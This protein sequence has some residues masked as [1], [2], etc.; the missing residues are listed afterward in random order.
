MWYVSGAPFKPL[1]DLVPFLVVAAALSGCLSADLTKISSSSS[2]KNGSSTSLSISAITPTIGASSSSTPVTITGTGFSGTVIVTIGGLACTGV[3]IV[4]STQLTCVASSGGGSGTYDLIVTVGST[5]ATLGN[6]FTW[7]S[8]P[9]VTSVSPAGGPLAGGTSITVTGGN[10]STSGGSPIV[11]IG[12]LTCGSLLYIDSTQLTCSTPGNSAGAYSATVTNADTQSGSLASA[13]SYNNAPTVSGF[14][15]S[16]GS[17][18][19]GTTITVDGTG[20][21]SSP[22]PTVTVAGSSCGSVNVLSATQLQCVTSAHGTTFGSVVVTNYD[23]QL[24]TSA[25]SYSYNPAPTISSLS[26]NNGSQSGGTPLTITG[27]GFIAGASVD[28]G[29]STCTSVVVG[30]PTSLSCTT[31]THTPA[32]VTVTV[33][34]T[35]L[36]S[37]SL[38]NAFTF[39]AAPTVTSV[40]PSGGPL[41]GGTTI[42]ITGTGF[43]ALPS[44]ILVGGSSCTSPALL[45]STTLTCV[46]PAHGSGLVTVQ[47]N[48]P[49]GQIGSLAN[50]FSYNPAPTISSITPSSGLT[51]GGTTITITGTGFISL[52]SIVVGGVACTSPTFN[53]SV[54]VS[55]VTPAH[56]VGSYGVTLTNPDGQV[57]S[58][59]SSFTYNLPP[60]VVSS[61]SPPAGAMGGHTL[62]T[63][64]GSNFV[65]TPTSV[66]IGGIGCANVTF[67]NPSTI[68]CLTGAAAPGSYTVMVTNPD[69]QTGSLSNGYT[70][71]STINLQVPFELADNQLGSATT[72]TQHLHT[73]L[74][75]D[76]ANFDGAVT[77]EF[78][79]VAD[80][81]SVSP[82]SVDLWD[83]TSAAVVATISVPVVGSS[84]TRFRA[85]FGTPAGQHIFNVRMG[86]TLSNGQ[87]T[88]YSARILVTQVGASRTEIYIPLTSTN[89]ANVLDQNGFV[90][91]TF[92]TTPVQVTQGNYA[93]WMKSSS[94]FSTLAAVNP[95]SLDVVIGAGATGITTATL[96]NQSSISVISATTTSTT[97]VEI[98]VP[99]S[100]ATSGFTPGNTFTMKFNGNGAANAYLYRSGLRVRLN[101]A[102]RAEVYY[103]VGPAF[104]STFAGYND[105]NGRALID[106][107][108]FSNPLA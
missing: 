74:T 83:Q 103:R 72:V 14:S 42:T 67:V 87:S 59:A 52:P 80:N 97:P 35:D 32:T 68:T 88:V 48:N 37:G 1:R 33:A 86:A 77:Y 41:A 5:N 27:T 85:Q 57:G 89:T 50:A 15:P 93:M 17:I 70:Y 13:F 102:I 96:Y 47:V 7:T 19:G 81:Y 60:P 95:W 12:G 98:L 66:M 90:D 106:L 73:S 3:T 34:N 4:N 84:P 92:S 76:P 55:C 16:G 65:A 99:F 6:A 78:E 79:I 26:A 29:G 40:S 54:S 51:T 94:A 11:T 101:P 53:S 44:S 58:L 104:S 49:D 43:Y 62:V 31:T 39:N 30:S 61:V 21:I 18:A 22:A 82:V 8:A 71:N 10:F 46:T 23:A 2:S 69:T 107:A 75:L 28:L 108:N 91:T 45:N 63:I 24:G 64:T 56:G 105:E 25:G 38:A 20:F 9:Y 36:Q 100:D